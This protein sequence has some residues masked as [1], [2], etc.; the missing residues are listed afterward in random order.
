MASGKILVKR[1]LIARARESLIEG[2]LV[3]DSPI[4]SR[5][6]GVIEHE[7]SQGHQLL[8]TLQ[9]ENYLY[10]YF[11]REASKSRTGK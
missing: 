5:Q 2:R 8:F 6:L 3:A 1:I 11:W 10:L 9:R 7:L 4:S